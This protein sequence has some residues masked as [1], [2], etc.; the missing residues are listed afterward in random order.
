M[1]SDLFGCP[2]SALDELTDEG[3]VTMPSSLAAGLV[4]DLPQREYPVKDRLTEVSGAPVIERTPEELRRRD[5]LIGVAVPGY[6]KNCPNAHERGCP[7]PTD[8]STAVREAGG[9]FD[10]STVTAYGKALVAE[11]A[12]MVIQ[13]GFARTAGTCKGLTRFILA[14]IVAE[15]VAYAQT[16]HHRFQ[17]DAAEILRKDYLAQSRSVV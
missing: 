11:K 10:H 7:A 16:G 15:D 4:G 6:I 17:S 1:S 2:V 8:I 14:S 12:D 5:E 13:F 9:N 3:V